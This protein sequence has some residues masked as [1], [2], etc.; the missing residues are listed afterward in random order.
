MKFIYFGIAMMGLVLQGCNSGLGLQTPPSEEDQSFV[1]YYLED[2]REVHIHARNGVGNEAKTTIIPGPGG[3]FDTKLRASLRSGPF[4]DDYLEE[5]FALFDSAWETNDPATGSPP[6]KIHEIWFHGS[7]GEDRFTNSTD[8][9]SIAFGRGGNDT[10]TGGTSTDELHGHDD[11]DL[12]SGDAGDDFLYGGFGSDVLFGGPGDDY[13]HVKATGNDADN[14][15]LCGGNGADE[16]NAAP[17]VS[18]SLDSETAGG[19]DGDVDILRGVNTSSA[20]TI[21]EFVQGNDVIFENGNF[22]DPLSG[23]LPFSQVIDCG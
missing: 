7:S 9:P 11:I 17:F 8:I 1:I 14:N 13:L 4:D 21:Y 19:D 6:R 5:D 23:N 3:P 10:L 16:L 2:V 20:T 15:V 18:N 12:L 22:I